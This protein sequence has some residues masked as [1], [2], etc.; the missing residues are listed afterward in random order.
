[1][2]KHKHIAGEKVT[3]QLAQYLNQ[4]RLQLENRQTLSLLQDGQFC[5]L[6]V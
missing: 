5:P 4:L 6:A 2:S 3:L 1:M